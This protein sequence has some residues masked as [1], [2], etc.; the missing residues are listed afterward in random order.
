MI[1]NRKT[2][3]CSICHFYKSLDKFDIKIGRLL[4]R[5]SECKYCRSINRTDINTL[6]VKKAK[7]VYRKTKKGKLKEKAYNNSERHKQAIILWKRLNKQK[8]AAHSIAKRANP[9]KHRC[10]KCGSTKCLQR[11][12]LDYA[13]PK[14]ILWVCASCH[15]SIHTAS[16]KKRRYSLSTQ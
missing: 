13:K 7:I 1:K 2:K 9:V 11:H 10:I 6:S 8:V 16:S 15:R 12:H 5:R 4:N 3:K 14:E